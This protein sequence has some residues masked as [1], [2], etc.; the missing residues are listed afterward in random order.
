[1]EQSG[2]V[3]LLPLLMLFILF[4]FLLIKPQQ[5]KAQQKKKMIDELK[6]GDILVLTSGFICEVDD[7]PAGKEYIFV[8]LNDNNIVRVFKDAII[9]KY[10]ENNKQK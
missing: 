8:R 6:V 9:G 4:Y 10:E 7:I 3:S 2:I 5:K 1:M